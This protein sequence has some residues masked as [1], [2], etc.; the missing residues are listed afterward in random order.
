[1]FCVI[2]RNIFL[3]SILTSAY[4]EVITFEKSGVP[5]IAKDDGKVDTHLPL[6]S[7]FSQSD[8]YACLIEGKKEKCSKDDVNYMK[9]KL[10][11][12]VTPQQ[13]HVAEA[14]NSD[15]IV[16]EALSEMKR[17]GK[18]YFGP[19]YQPI[20]LHLPRRAMYQVISVEK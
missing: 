3:F 1:M 11:E 19:R 2:S 12:G 8:R 18:V 6:S 14:P 13:T 7:L 4:A 9:N 5:N 15:K 17:D 20:H 10:G 16:D